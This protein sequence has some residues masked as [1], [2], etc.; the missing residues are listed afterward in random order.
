MTPNEKRSLPSTLYT[1]EYFLTA[2]EGYDVFLESEGQHL[3]RRLNDAFVMADVQPGMRV[4][5]VGCGR[6]EIVRHCMELG[7]EAYGID[8][9]EVAALMT[10]DVITAEQSRITDETDGQNLHA[11]VCR[12]DAKTLPFPTN[13]FDRVLMFDVVEHLYPWELHAAMLDTKRVLK[14]NG[15]FIIHT[16]PNKWYDQ[17]AY[18]WVRRVRSLMGQGQKYP[19]DPRAIT[20]VN[21]DVH[22]NEQDLLSMRQALKKAGFGNINVW[23]DSPP[24]NRQESALMAALRRIAF[25]VPPFRWFF[26]REVFAVA[27][28]VS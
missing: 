15:R 26:E 12:S 13:Y 19:K 14:T 7:I 10:R 28:K 23:L 21:Q 24:Q 9:A 5:D 16:A 11:G 4:L 17:Y 8:Y 27:E 25:D 3:S 1:E 2:C 6:G 20:P 22:V 18:P